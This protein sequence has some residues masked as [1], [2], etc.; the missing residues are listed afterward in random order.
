MFFI[1]VLILIAAIGF[2]NRYLLKKTNGQIWQLPLLDKTAKVLP[3]SIV[4]F[5]ILW[6]LGSLSNLQWLKISGATLTGIILIINLMLLLT[7]PFSFG[8]HL[9]SRIFKPEPQKSPLKLKKSRRMFLKSAAAAAPVFAIGRASEGFASSFS[10][11]RFPQIEMP[12][13]NLPDDLDG[14]RILHL[15]DLHLGYYFGLDH[16]ENTLQNAEKYDPDLIA[17]TGDIADDLG[18]MTDAMKLIDQLKTPYNKYVI[19]GNH[20]HFR[21]IN[22]AIR[23]INAGPVPLLFNQNDTFTIGGTKLTIAG[24]DDPVRMRAD[25]TGFLDNAVDIAFNGAAQADFRLLLSHRP[26]AL[27]VAEKYN[28]D[29]TLSG[30]THGGQVGFA[31]RSLWEIINENGYLWGSYQKG[32]SQL[33]TS[34]GMGHWFPFRLNCPLEAP[35]ITLKKA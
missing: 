32:N 12:F 11:T 1:L 18:L 4:P 28:I 34:A 26:R 7:L 33:Y 3:Y 31:G 9:L 24:V 29:L 10:E 2:V 13:K 25:I 23:R 15:S 8:T 5:L 21:G 19:V 20:E 35:V 17:V 22:E 27:D 30:H 6:G 16:L 14:I